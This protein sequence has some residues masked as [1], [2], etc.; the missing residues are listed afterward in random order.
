MNRY[1]GLPIN[2]CRCTAPP[3]TLPTT[4]LFKTRRHVVSLYLDETQRRKPQSNIQYKTGKEETA[5]SLT[6]EL[7]LAQPPLVLALAYK[8]H[9]GH[10]Q[11]DD[12]MMYW[13][14]TYDVLDIIGS[15]FLQYL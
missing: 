9:I 12:S 4:A 15:Q 5:S 6:S 14:C 11:I 2:V 1:V 13:I 10:T 8:N 7:L 3:V